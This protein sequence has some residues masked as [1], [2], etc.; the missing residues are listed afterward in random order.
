M[1][2]LSAE[3]LAELRRRVRTSVGNVTW[4]K[5]QINAAV[6]ATENWFEANRSSL[7]SAIDTATSPHS[8]TGAQKKALV[9]YWMLQK[10]AREGV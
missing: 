6:Q 2:V 4:T 8:F 5:P 10:F 3:E 1:A 7:V 9:A